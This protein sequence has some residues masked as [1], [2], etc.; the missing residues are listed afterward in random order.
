[1]IK[2]PLVWKP[3]EYQIWYSITCISKGRGKLSISGIE[4]KLYANAYKHGLLNNPFGFK[5]EFDLEEVGFTKGLKEGKMFK[6]LTG[7]NNDFN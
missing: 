1:M 7:K 4:Q 2:P 3:R 5:P 6:L